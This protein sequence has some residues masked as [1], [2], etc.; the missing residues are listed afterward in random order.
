MSH[1]STFRSSSHDA[2][3]FVQCCLARV[4]VR[5]IRES[6]EIY[7]CINVS[8]ISI[9]ILLCQWQRERSLLIVIFMFYHSS[10]SLSFDPFRFSTVGSFSFCPFLF[11]S[12]LLSKWIRR[13]LAL[14]VCLRCLSVCPP[15][16]PLPPHR[17]FASYLE[18]N[19][20]KA[21]HRQIELKRRR[22]KRK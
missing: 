19:S 9:Y 22:R 5:G 14:H 20:W 17:F 13:V 15:P 21:K 8:I 16:R 2:I 10:S 3:D 18:F 6:R 12:F 4:R 7:L 1:C 11:S